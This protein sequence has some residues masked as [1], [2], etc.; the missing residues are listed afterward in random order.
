M[1]GSTQA[2]AN[3]A[4]QSSPGLT[5]SHDTKTR[6]TTRE[7]KKY[8]AISVPTKRHSAGPTHS[9]DTIVCA[10]RML[11]S[12]ANN[13]DA[14]VKAYETGIIARDRNSKLRLR[15][16]RYPGARAHGLAAMSH[17]G[18]KTSWRPTEAL[19]MQIADR[20]SASASTRRARPKRLS[21]HQIQRER[22]VIPCFGS[23]IFVVV[24][25]I[26]SP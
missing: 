20:I 13:G 3:H 23:P 11:S 18:T 9:L 25:S 5:I 4:T 24:R 10:I 6:F 8:A 17:A 14:V 16:P 1:I 2:Q 15:C 7:S 12:T 21:Q 19:V 26:A 22:R